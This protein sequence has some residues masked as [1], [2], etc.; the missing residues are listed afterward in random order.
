MLRARASGELMSNTVRT[1][2]SGPPAT[3]PPSSS[4][5]P[6][7]TSTPPAPPPPPTPS[8]PTPVAAPTPAAPPPSWAHW[9]SCREKTCCTR[10]ARH[11]NGADIVRISRT[12]ALEPWHFTQTSPAAADDPAGIILAGGRRRVNLT[13]ANAGH[14]C[15]FLIRTISGAACCG[16]GDLAPVSCRAFPADPTTSVEDETA[17]RADHGC[18]CREWTKT[19]LDQTHTD[20]LR[21]EWAADHAHWL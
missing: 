9:K 8:A 3:P 4:K 15:V 18:D 10:G 6:P 14:G 2:K 16:I 12:L 11:V 1:V 19:D 17:V 5:P 20:E 13:L 7:S 21:Q